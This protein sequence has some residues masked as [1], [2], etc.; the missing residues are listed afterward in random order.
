M[1]TF[2]LHLFALKQQELGKVIVSTIN[3]YTILCTH[4]ISIKILKILIATTNA[5]I[6]GAMDIKPAKKELEPS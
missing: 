1:P 5:A 2:F 6:F 3:K 4:T